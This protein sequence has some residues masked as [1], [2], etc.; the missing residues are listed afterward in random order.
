MLKCNVACCCRMP[1]DE[2]M[3]KR[4]EKVLRLAQLK[5][6]EC[7]LIHKPTN[8]FYLSGYTI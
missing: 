6:N 3:M 2:N 4:M 7:V 5:E 1:E 8:M